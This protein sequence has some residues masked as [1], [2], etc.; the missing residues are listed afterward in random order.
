MVAPISSD[1]STI[2][3]RLAAWASHMSGGVMPL[4]SDAK[5]PTARLRAGKTVASLES[6]QS[7]QLGTT[8]VPFGLGKSISVNLHGELSEEEQRLVE[9]LRDRDTEVRRHE[10]AHLM[11]AGR[12]V[13]GSPSYTYQVGPD[14]Q[15][16]AVGGEVK[17]DLAPVDGDPEATLA[18]ARQ[19][20]QAALAPSEPSA[21][22][23]Q[24]AMMASR[25]AQDAMRQITEERLQKQQK[26]DAE[27]A[28]SEGENTEAPGGREASDKTGQTVSGVAMEKPFAQSADEEEKSVAKDAPAGNSETATASGTPQTA[29]LNQSIGLTGMDNLDI[30]I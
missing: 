3:R 14:G 20:Q 19:L 25:L 16:Y 11:A 23:R 12:Y 6:S 1:E 21:T 28:D 10:R 15:R 26:A 2:T 27:K 9:Q 29:S 8:P 7:G 24:V 13:I 18:K 17:V 22:D 30:Y 5:R 4:K